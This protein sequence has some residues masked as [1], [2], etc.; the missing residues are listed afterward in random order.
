MPVIAKDVDGEFVVFGSG[1]NNCADYTRARAVKGQAY[2]VYKQWLMGYLSAFNVIVSNTYDI[3][4]E[5]NYKQ[6]R[7]WLDSY[8]KKNPKESFVNASAMLTVKL[9]PE[10][11]NLAP[12]KDTSKKWTESGNVYSADTPAGTGETQ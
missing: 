10:R 9:Y 4:G 2:Q 1:E 11:R 8:C 6:V 5:R 12:N 7:R 3:L